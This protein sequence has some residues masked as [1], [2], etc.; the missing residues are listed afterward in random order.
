MHKQNPTR[1]NDQEHSKKKKKRCLHRWDGNSVRGH[2][3]ESVWA[4]GL[5][6]YPG[7]EGEKNETP[8]IN[9]SF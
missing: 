4:P 7:K 8:F 5:N 9:V 2:L 1:F 6:H 3:P